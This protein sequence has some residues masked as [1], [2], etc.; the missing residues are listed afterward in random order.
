MGEE[1]VFVGL[2]SNIGK[3]G[4]NLLIATE[5]LRDH[6]NVSLKVSSS[7]YLTEP[8]GFKDQPSFINNVIEISTTLTPRD[9]LNLLLYIE[10]SMGRK[11]LIHWGPRVIDMD[12]LFYGDRVIKEEGLEIP[13][14]R[15]I[16]RAFVLIP[17]SEIAPDFLHPIENMTIS[18]LMNRLPSPVPFVIKIS[19]EEEDFFMDVD[20][21]QDQLNGSV[22]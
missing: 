15:L 1:R 12:I 21:S 2:G 8:V 17:L 13:H 22:A 14:P 11:R 5:M 10:N 7:F 16:E 4:Y 6:P 3:R 19:P 18:Q 20:S 9:L